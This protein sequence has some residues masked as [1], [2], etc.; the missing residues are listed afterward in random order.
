MTVKED[1][2]LI[3][4]K[5]GIKVASREQIITKAIIPQKNDQILKEPQKK[6]KYF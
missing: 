3:S 5:H 2:I 1:G 4:T 6:V